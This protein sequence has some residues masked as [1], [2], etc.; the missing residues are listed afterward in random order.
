[1][2]SQGVSLNALKTLLIAANPLY[3]IECPCSGVCAL[4][5]CGGRLPTTNFQWCICIFLGLMQ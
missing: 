5:V 4:W 3:N 1:M 2:C